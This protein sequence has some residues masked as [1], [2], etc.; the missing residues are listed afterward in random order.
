MLISV[1]AFE[2]SNRVM[3]ALA[4]QQANSPTSAAIDWPTVLPV[5]ISIVTVLVPPFFD[6]LAERRALRDWASILKA[7][8]VYSRW[9]EIGDLKTVLRLK[10][11]ID[12][13]IEQQAK[14]PSD[15]WRYAIPV[16]CIL[17]EAALALWVLIRGNLLSAVPV[18]IAITLM[19]MM[20]R[21]SIAFNNMRKQSLY[22]I[23]DMYDEL[24]GKAAN[25]ASQIV[26]Y[27]LVYKTLEKENEMDARMA[28]IFSSGDPLTRRLYL[29]ALEKERRTHSQDTDEQE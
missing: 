28:E 15:V 24:M 23:D 16:I 9:A 26:G 22:G 20:L 11:F 29:S 3:L 19:V 13:L 12:I 27:D 10:R 25:T 6:Y 5:V 7:I 14:A 18:I 21:R 1:D 4:T 8:D 2:I 17:I